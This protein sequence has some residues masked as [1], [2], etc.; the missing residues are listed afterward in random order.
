[1]KRSLYG[2]LQYYCFLIVVSTF[3]LHKRRVIVIPM[4]ALLQVGCLPLWPAVV[5]HRQSLSESSRLPAPSSA[6]D[7]HL[8]LRG[9]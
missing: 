5:R 8:S 2:D 6:K 3:F 7:F 4:E 9:Y 1:M